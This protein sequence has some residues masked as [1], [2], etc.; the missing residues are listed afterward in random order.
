MFSLKR[1][2]RKKKKV[3]GESVILDVPSL[4]VHISG[5]RLEIFGFVGSKIKENHNNRNYIS[6]SADSSQLCD[7]VEICL[8]FKI[9]TDSVLE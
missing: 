2:K 5:G 8:P 6:Q 3:T 9:I 4:S 1:P 7:R